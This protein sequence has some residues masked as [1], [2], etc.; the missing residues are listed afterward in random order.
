MK[1]KIFACI[2]IVS[3]FL[4]CF[5]CRAGDSLKPEPPRDSRI[6]RFADAEGSRADPEVRT[7]LGPEILSLIQDADKME[8]CRIGRHPNPSETDQKIQG[9]TVIAKG[10]DL[11]GKDREAVRRMLCSASSY[12][13]QWSKRT[14]IRPSHALRVRGK[15]EFLDIAVDFS[16]RQWSFSFRNLYREEDISKSAAS[17]LHEIMDQ[18]LGRE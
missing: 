10:S 2:S 15:G 13:F 6:M 17:V 7:F 8:I 12:E 11:K 3:V 4:I 16:S 14:R 9:Y 1:R 18:A 5:S